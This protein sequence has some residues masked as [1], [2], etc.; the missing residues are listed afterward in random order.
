VLVWLALLGGGQHTPLRSSARA[1]QHINTSLSTTTTTT[2][3]TARTQVQFP[4]K[5]A[6]SPEGRAFLSRCLAHHQRD[7]WDVLT[8]AADPYLQLKR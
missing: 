8:A 1:T 4:A 2:T 3:P 7:R 5:P 6:V